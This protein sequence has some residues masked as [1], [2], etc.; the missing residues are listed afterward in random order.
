MGFG[1]CLRFNFFVI[2]SST[3]S[4]PLEGTR[5]T[6][7]RLTLLLDSQFQLVTRSVRPFF[8]NPEN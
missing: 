7:D 2:P 5:V 1:V 8:P 4:G 3:G 6:N